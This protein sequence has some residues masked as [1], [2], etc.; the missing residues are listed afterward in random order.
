MRSV[1]FINQ[2]EDGFYRIQFKQEGFD[3]STLDINEE[4]V[5]KVS[6]LS[7]SICVPANLVNAV[8]QRDNNLTIR[9]GGKDNR[10]VIPVDD[11]DIVQLTH[12]RSIF[13]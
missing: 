9:L 10:V 1:A 2:F 6:V 13:L 4:L 7:N 5:P 12:H 8:Q 3:V 11:K